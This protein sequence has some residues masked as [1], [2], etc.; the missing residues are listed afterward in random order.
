MSA[1]TIALSQ[2][3]YRQVAERVEALPGVEGVSLVGMFPTA[4]SATR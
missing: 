4:P 3:F 1:N 2:E